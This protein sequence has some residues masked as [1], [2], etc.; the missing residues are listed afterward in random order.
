MAYER[1]PS[2]EAEIA[3]IFAALREEVRS[4]EPAIRDG[5]EAAHARPLVARREAQR[6]WP[7]TAE[8]P[9][10]Y[11]PGS[12]GRARG[13]ALVPVKAVLR[14]LMRWY[15][16]P[17]ATDQRAFNAAML[18]LADELADRLTSEARRLERTLEG[19]ADRVSALEAD[20]APAESAT[21]PP[22]SS[23]S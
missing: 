12:W 16:E 9:Y 5:A 6:L 8:R 14:R 13:L 20:G 23:H 21:S 10:L 15:V 19:L 4:R 11:K 22:P 7:V 17:L 2:E 18:R 3:A 1:L